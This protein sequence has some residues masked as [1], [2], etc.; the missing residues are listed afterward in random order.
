[1]GCNYIKGQ[2]MRWWFWCVSLFFGSGIFCI[3]AQS[4]WATATQSEQWHMLCFLTL[5]VI[6][7]KKSTNNSFLISSS[8][9]P[10]SYPVYT[11]MC[12]SVWKQHID[13]NHR[14]RT[15]NQTVSYMCI[16]R[17]GFQLQTSDDFIACIKFV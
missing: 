15:L 3:E 6:R 8:L 16:S 12:M 7:K 14:S 10:N 5:H 11:V 4:T 17:C 9:G 2:W 13:I 1:V